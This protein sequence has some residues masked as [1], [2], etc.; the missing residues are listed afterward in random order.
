[1]NYLY[2]PENGR[3]EFLNQTI[4]TNPQQL[5]SQRTNGKLK[6]S[7]SYLL[8]EGIS[9]EMLKNIPIDVN[10]L[11][12]LEIVQLER[13]ENIFKPEDTIRY[14]YFPESAVVSEFQI[15]ENGK[16]VEISMIGREGAVGI[17][18]VFNVNQT[19]NFSQILISGK[20]FRLNLQFFQKQISVCHYFQQ[21][22]YKYL[23]QYIS[24]IS[25]RV[26]CNSQHSTEERFCLWLLMINERC[27]KT[28]LPLTQ[29]QIA[30]FLGVHR[31]SVTL[32]TQNLRSEGVIDY[33]RGK[34]S[35]TDRQ[36]LK[37]RACTCYSAEKET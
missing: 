5:S 17:N 27:G 2:K 22:I 6:L 12:A 3:S 26:V 20:A 18:A 8:A 34:I 9:N 25:Q 33:V 36:K 13:C 23:N 24:Q 14:L 29:E 15:L 4:F 37:S 35:I 31:P 10:F 7:Q 19:Q 16:T 28:S 11:S 21:S 30:R 32:I 1:M